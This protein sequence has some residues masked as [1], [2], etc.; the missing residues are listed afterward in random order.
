MRDLDDLLE[1][2]EP[3]SPEDLLDVMFHIA[4]CP[5]CQ[6]ALRGLELAMLI[7]EFGG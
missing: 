4:S 1:G 5:N 3:I 6:R 2:D 7:E